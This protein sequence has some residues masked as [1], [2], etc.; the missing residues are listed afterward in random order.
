MAKY[1]VLDGA[2]Y[3]FA[4]EIEGNIYE[5][6]VPDDRSNSVR[7]TIDHYHDGYK[8][9]RQW[10]LGS[11]KVELVKEKRV[12]TKPKGK[13]NK[14]S[15]RKLEI[16]YVDGSKYHLV[17]VKAVTVD[18]TRSKVFITYTENK[19]FLKSISIELDFKDLRRIIFEDKA[20]QTTYGYS[21][22]KG[23]MLASAKAAPASEFPKYILH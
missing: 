8:P 7:L 20:A 4:S 5:G 23:A 19:G 16:D 9:G 2:G 6:Y 17:N 10:H 22:Y 14:P 11:D 18:S 12:K 21:F 3:T 1:K 13:P 15:Q